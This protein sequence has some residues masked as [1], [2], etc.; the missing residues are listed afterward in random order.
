M[1]RLPWWSIKLLHYSPGLTPFCSASTPPLPS[2]IAQSQPFSAIYAEHHGHPWLLGKAPRQ[3]RPVTQWYPNAPLSYEG[4]P[5]RFRPLVPSW[6]RYRLTFRP[7][8]RLMLLWQHQQTPWGPLHPAL[9]QHMRSA[10]GSGPPDT[11]AGCFQCW[12]N[13]S[14]GQCNASWS[15]QR[16]LPSKWAHP[17]A[18]SLSTCVV[19]INHQ[20]LKRESGPNQ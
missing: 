12:G 4:L 7:P 15:I 9:S 17:F 1:I 8:P 19:I 18:T 11:L 10:L 5:S 3:E 6:V 16:C 14:S 13:M 20:D 2:M